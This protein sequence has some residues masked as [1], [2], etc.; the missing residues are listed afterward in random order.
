MNDNDM[1]IDPVFIDDIEEED[2]EMLS[3]SGANTLLRQFAPVGHSSQP[4]RLLT[5]SLPAS[6]FW[7][8]EKRVCNFESLD[9]F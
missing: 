8:N 7:R 6:I 9:V 5:F 4:F 3:Q 1:N 2:N